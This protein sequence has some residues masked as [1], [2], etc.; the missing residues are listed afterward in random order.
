[1]H[2]D[3]NFAKLEFIIFSHY[4]MIVVVVEEHYVALVLETV[5]FV[6]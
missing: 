5:G 4:G 1:M 6:I 2:E 3:L